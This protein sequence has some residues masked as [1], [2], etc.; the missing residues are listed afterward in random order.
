M[1]EA[2]NLSAVAMQFLTAAAT[3]TGTGL[4]DGVANLI[5]ERLGESPTGVGALERFERSPEDPQ[6]ADEVSEL[7]GEAIT[8]N[9]A[10]A[11]RLERASI[12]AR[13]TAQGTG[14]TVHGNLSAVSISGRMKGNITIGPVT[15]SDTPKTRAALVGAGLVM[16][17]L[18]ALGAYGG[19]R[20]LEDS[21]PDKNSQGSTSGGP[22]SGQGVDPAVSGGPEGDQ[23]VDSGT[24]QP[25]GQLAVTTPDL[26]ASPFGWIAS[27]VTNA[28]GPVVANTVGAV[29]D[30]PA[31]QPVV[32]LTDGEPK[33]AEPV[34]L[35]PMSSLT[36]TGKG[37]QVKLLLREYSDEREAK[38]TIDHSIAAIRD[39]PSFT[40][41][42][43]P[44]LVNDSVETRVIAAGDNNLA[45]ERVEFTLRQ[46]SETGKVQKGEEYLRMTAI[47]KG[48][49]LAVFYQ[50]ESS[51]SG[52]APFA[53]LP[54]E[55]QSKKLG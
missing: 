1:V 47:R 16:V 49:R 24:S 52:L 17:A 5:R 50:G 44:D 39:C 22:E 14:N 51:V 27:P 2:E 32:D 54:I 15:M 4:G 40:V 26:S 21:S 45:G 6:A 13:A 8:A 43:S 25:L 46:S 41:D 29:A 42:L 38:D 34:L 7:V 53:A 55:E 37:W 3:G 18:L 9:P 12:T 31:C 48:A 36:S 35:G 28:N 33:G 30:D 20:M 11:E 19:V 10:F 23:G